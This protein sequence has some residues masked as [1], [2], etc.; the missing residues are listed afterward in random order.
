MLYEHI[1][2]GPY[3]VFQTVRKMEDDIKMFRCF[4]EVGSK[5]GYCVSVNGLYN[6]YFKL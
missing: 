1:A 5:R 3:L 4:G 2:V 6:C